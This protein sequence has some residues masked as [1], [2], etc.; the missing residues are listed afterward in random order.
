MTSKIHTRSSFP[1]RG[2][3]AAAVALVALATGCGESKGD[4]PRS[5]PTAQSQVSVDVGEVFTLAVDENASTGERWYLDSPEP[6]ASVVRSRGDDYQ[7]DAEDADERPGVGGTRVFT[8][9]ATGAG[10]AEIVLLHCP[11]YT[12]T[13]GPK[14][15]APASPSAP[16]AASRPAPERTTYT[17]TVT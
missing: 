11:V 1:S 13:G 16:A 9:E 2:V 10:R 8:F 14:S 4:S 5:H 6:D 12:C 3:L 15:P 17:V 7:P